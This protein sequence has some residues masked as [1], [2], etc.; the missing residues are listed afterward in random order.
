MPRCV[1]GSL[2]FSVILLC[3]MSGALKS[4][5]DSIPEMKTNKLHK[6]VLGIKHSDSSKNSVHAV[7]SDDEQTQ[8]ATTPAGNERAPLLKG[9]FYYKKA[10]LSQGE[11]CDAAVNFDMY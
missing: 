3:L 4:H 10:V 8:S 9:F 2:I 6:H 5:E 11:P 7:S 1:L